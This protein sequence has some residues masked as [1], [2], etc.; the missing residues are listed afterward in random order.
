MSFETLSDIKKIST[1]AIG[2]YQQAYITFKE[3]KPVEKFF[4]I[5]SHNIYEEI[6]RII[7]LSLSR[8]QRDL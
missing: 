8:E 1:K 3:K 6:V 4:N 5:W 7:L 2:L